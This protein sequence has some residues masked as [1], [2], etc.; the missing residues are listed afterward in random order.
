[1]AVEV[2][3][4]II[5]F[6][7]SQKLTI[8]T[9]VFCDNSIVIIQNNFILKENS[10][11]DQKAEDE[12]IKKERHK[13]YTSF[14]IYC[15]FILL[16]VFIIAL[17]GWLKMPSAEV[18]ISLAVNELSFKINEDW[19]IY[20]IEA[21]NLRMAN[22]KNLELH[23]IKFEEA[24]AYDSVTYRPTKWQNHRAEDIIKITGNKEQKWWNVSFRSEYLKLSSLYIK[25]GANIT[26]AMNEYKQ[27]QYRLQ[28]RNATVMGT[29][30]TGEI[31]EIACNHCQIT[32]ES[33]GINTFSRIFRIE[34]QN[35]EIEFGDQD[36]LIILELEITQ[37]QR[38]PNSCVF[39]RSINIDSI[40]FSALEG[41]EI[42]ST[43][44][45]DGSIHY[46]QLDGKEYEINS[47][48]FLFIDGPK[49]FQIKR[50]ILGDQISV[51]LNGKVKKLKSGSQKYLNSRMPSILE[52]S[53]KNRSLTLFIGT[54]TAVFAFLFALWQLFNSTNTRKR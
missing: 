19:K 48:D 54:L 35:R 40:G 45:Q 33:A 13:Y 7:I 3:S 39:G 41:N 4:V 1:M 53:R 34:T 15:L 37:K 2:L 47:G 31:F 30:E 18:T 5:S 24:I 20:S 17:L 38:S 8:D 29:V 46:A 52:W 16:A 6:I 21:D 51:T 26:V 50:L 32:D 27:N 36:G 42:V 11:S 23:P 12:H 43:I 9:S 25:S 14:K 44:T 49:D 10:M 28:I 22:F